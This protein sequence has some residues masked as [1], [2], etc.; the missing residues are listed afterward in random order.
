[1]EGL[2]KQ[3]VTKVCMCEFVY[4]EICEVQGRKLEFMK[5]LK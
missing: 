1:M 3:S 2:H 5:F 4:S